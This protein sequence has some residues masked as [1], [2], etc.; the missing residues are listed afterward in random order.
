MAE[1]NLTL[2]S[3]R[4]NIDPSTSAGRMLAGIF[5]TMA[6][7]ERAIISERTR[8]GMRAAR[9]KGKQIGN[10]KRWFDEQKAAELRANGWGQVRYR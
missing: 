6:E 3:C 4:E 2:V 8:A 9:A 10:R 1:R 7:Y 5:A